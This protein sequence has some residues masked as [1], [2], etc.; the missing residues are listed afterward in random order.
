MLFQTFHI[1][2]F[3]LSVIYATCG[4]SGINLKVA[5]SWQEIMRM[6]RTSALRVI[7]THRIPI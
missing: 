7:Q 6:P 2:W 5:V 3:L 4:T 1:E